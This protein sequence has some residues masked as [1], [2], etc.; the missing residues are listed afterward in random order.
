LVALNDY[1]E[2][3]RVTALYVQSTSLVEFLC[4]QK[5][6]PQAFT[7]FV[8]EGLEGSFE[9]ALQRHY[10]FR[11]FKDLEER[12]SQAAADNSSSR[13]ALYSPR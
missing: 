8:R 11:D 10:G 9:A 2:S 1:P 6:G 5:G 7:R 13:A 12:W 3:R 4:A